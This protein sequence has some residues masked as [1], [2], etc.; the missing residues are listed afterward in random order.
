MPVEVET[1]TVIVAP[2][3]EVAAYASDPG[4]ATSWYENIVAARWET[5]KPLAAGSRFASVAAPLLVS[6]MRR[7]N[8][9]D[10]RRLKSLLERR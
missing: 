5:P 6:A 9:K 7:A 8:T 2:R 3:E 10:L 1:Q 4:N